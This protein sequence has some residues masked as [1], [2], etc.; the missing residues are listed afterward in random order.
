[1]IKG[2]IPQDG[3]TILNVYVLKNRALKYVRQNLI[4]LQIEK[5]KS[6]ITLRDFNTPLLKMDKSSRYK[7]NKDVVE[8]NRIIN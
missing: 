6:T 5:D 7:S 3:I 2:L 1:M 4:E 8:C